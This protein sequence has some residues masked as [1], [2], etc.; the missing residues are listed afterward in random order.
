MV[1]KH[2][3][4]LEKQFS[5]LKT[6]LLDSLLEIN[7]DEKQIIEILRKREISEELIDFSLPYIRTEIQKNVPS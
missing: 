6:V 3:E 2:H 4:I 5:T 1:S 7:S